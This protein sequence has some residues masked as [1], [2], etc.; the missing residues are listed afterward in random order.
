M[1]RNGNGKTLLRT[2]EF[3]LCVVLL[4]FCES[5]SHKLQ[6]QSQADVNWKL[7]MVPA[8]P[9]TKENYTIFE[10]MYKHVLSQLSLFNVQKYC[11]GELHDAA[12]LLDRFLNRSGFECIYEAQ[13]A[14]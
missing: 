11:L 13:N 5:V 12:Q 1:D 4:Y 14:I 9:K 3:V 10:I 6:V 2:S 7:E 8:S